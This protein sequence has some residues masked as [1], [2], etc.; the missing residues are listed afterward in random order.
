MT[1]RYTGVSWQKAASSWQA[2]ISIK[3]KQY[4]LGYYAKEDEA[5]AA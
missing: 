5:A 4:G 3:G 1:S 2:K